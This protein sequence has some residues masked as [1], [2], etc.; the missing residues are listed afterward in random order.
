MRLFLL[1]IAAGLLV[2]ALFGVG[3]ARGDL[4]ISVKP[5]VEYRVRATCADGLCERFEWERELA[6]AGSW[7]LFADG[8]SLEV[9]DSIASGVGARYRLR[10]YV[11]GFE[12][13]ESGCEPIG[14]RAYSEWSEPSDWVFGLD[15][16]PG[17][18]SKPSYLKQG[19]SGD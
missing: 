19:D 3:R 2:S 4:T 9:R 16:R 18:C 11:Q 15:D 5:G 17:A 10:A 7:V 14:E 8:T 13:S 12:C 6:G 1:N